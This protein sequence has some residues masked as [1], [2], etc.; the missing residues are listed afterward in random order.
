M[1]TRQRNILIY[2]VLIFSSLA[3]CTKM[4]PGEQKEDKDNYY[5]KYVA[6]ENSS[7]IMLT[8]IVIST[9]NGD[10]TFPASSEFE[11]TVG[12]VQKGFQAHITVNGKGYTKGNPAYIEI[13]VSKN[14][15]PFIIKLLARAN[16]G[17]G[18]YDIGYGSGSATF[19]VGSDE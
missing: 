5:V 16:V 1:I 11:Q 9:P 8:D 3:S 18:V 13:H 2:I 7:R 19:Y 17:T 6:Y 12:P 15:E 14:K 10:M 4:N